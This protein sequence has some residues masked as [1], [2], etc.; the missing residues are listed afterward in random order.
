MVKAIVKARSDL[1]EEIDETPKCI[2]RSILYYMLSKSKKVT[3]DVACWESPKE[4]RSCLLDILTSKIYY[5]TLPNVCY[6]IGIAYI[7]VEDSKLIEQSE[8]TDKL[9]SAYIKSVEKSRICG[10]SIASNIFAM[11]KTSKYFALTVQRIPTKADMNPK[12]KSFIFI[13]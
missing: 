6:N 3:S 9:L 8:I 7:S 10:K 1:D 2:S 5:K 12:P 4:Q 13:N 11:F